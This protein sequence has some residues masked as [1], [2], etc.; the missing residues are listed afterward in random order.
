MVT[1]LWV[2]KPID[3]LNE[4]PTRLHDPAIIVQIDHLLVMPQ[5]Q[6]VEQ[7]VPEVDHQDGDPEVQ[8]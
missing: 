1:D 4:I 6:A 2:E 3:P 7:I 8:L 5:P